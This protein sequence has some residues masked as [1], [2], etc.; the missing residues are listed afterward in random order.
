MSLPRT[1]ASLSMAGCKTSG[2]NVAKRKSSFKA[3]PLCLDRCRV[4]ACEHNP[5][6]TR[7]TAKERRVSGEHTAR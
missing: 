6:L 1:A 4:N 5:I 2:K 7:A 3:S